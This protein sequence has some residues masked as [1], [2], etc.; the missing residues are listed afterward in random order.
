MIKMKTNNL[1]N[2]VLLGSIIGTISLFLTITAVQASLEELG[3][4]SSNIFAGSRDN[5]DKSDTTIF[6][7]FSPLQ[8]QVEGESNFTQENQSFDSTGSNASPDFEIYE[9]NL[10]IPDITQRVGPQPP[11]TCYS[12]FEF[13]HREA[14]SPPMTCISGSEPTQR[15]SPPAYAPEPKEEFAM[16]VEFAP[17]KNFDSYWNLT[18][19]G[20]NVSPGSDICPED[21]CE[22]EIEGGQLRPDLIGGYFFEGRL[23]VIVEEEAGTRSNMYNIRGELDYEATLKNSD[24]LTGY[25]DE[26]LKG[27][28]KIGKLKIDSGIIVVS[29]PLEYNISY[30]HFYYSENFAS[31]TLR[32][33]IGLE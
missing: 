1:C 32:G 20:L 11:G 14:S 25:T 2:I 16:N 24:I 13:T 17:D 7:G 6:E 31:L 15:E 18:G 28:L 4:T 27:K 3:D 26:I 19:F 8:S 30:G 12:L 23:K 5:S 22:F 10:P 33:A 29:A 21:N 9:S